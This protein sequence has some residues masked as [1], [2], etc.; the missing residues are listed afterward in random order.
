M[1][2][3]MVMEQ[4]HFCALFARKVS[5]TKFIP[6][7]ALSIFSRNLPLVIDFRPS[8]SISSSGENTSSMS[9]IIIYV[10]ESASTPL[11]I[12]FIQSEPW[13][14]AIDTIEITRSS[15]ILAKPLSGEQ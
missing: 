1:I 8:S 4:P 3:F 13:D 11:S 14:W 10:E 12:I 7:I 5:F 15:I 9:S 2:A 6:F